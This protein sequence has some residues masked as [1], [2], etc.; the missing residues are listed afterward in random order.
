MT[1][2]EKQQVTMIKPDFGFSD[3]VMQKTID[4][5]QRVLSDEHVFY[6]KLRNYHWN[7][8]GPTFIA[9]HELFEEQY[10]EL[11]ET[12][13][14]IAERVRSYGARSLGSMAEMLEHARLAEAAPGAMPT[15]R[16]MVADLVA[17]HEAMVRY[18]TADAEL[19]DDTDDLGAEDFLIG[20]LQW[21]QKQ[22]WLLRAHLEG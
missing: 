13:D 1:D 5:F 4:T 15:A 19:M 2:M 7:V 21:H 9:L 20:L 12:I 11:S 6:M 8:T 16:E 10:T 14:E 17:D 3:D 22:G 18:L